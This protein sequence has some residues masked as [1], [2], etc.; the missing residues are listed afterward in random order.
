MKKPQHISILGRTTFGQ[1]LAS[2]PLFSCHIA[3]FRFIPYN[4]FEPKPCPLLR[5]NSKTNKINQHGKKT[6]QRN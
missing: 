6:I 5:L 3:M 2:H 1:P 4:T